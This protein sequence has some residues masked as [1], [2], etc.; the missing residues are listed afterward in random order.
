MSIISGVFLKK[1]T[2][3]IPIHKKYSKVEPD[4]Y[5]PVSII[6]IISNIFERVVR[7]Q[8]TVHLIFNNYI[9]VQQSGLVFDSHFHQNHV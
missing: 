1:K 5:R 6:R 4:N 9:Y 2:K 8:L 7:E 3:V